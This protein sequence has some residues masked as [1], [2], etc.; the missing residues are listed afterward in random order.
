RTLERTL[1]EALRKGHVTLEAML[2]CI[3]RNG[4]RG[5]EGVAHL[6]SLL[7]ERRHQN[8]PDSELETDVAALLREHGIAAPVKRHRA[9]ED[10]HAIAEVDLAWPSEKVA[11]QVHGSSFHRRPRTW[12]N[13]QRVENRLQLHGWLVVKV[14][15]RM[16]EE[17]PEEFVA[18][19]ERA[20]S[21]RGARRVRRGVQNKPARARAAATRPCA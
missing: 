20:L 8:A 7:S 13:D 6:A 18:L 14:T 10:D 17:A 19:I 15:R 9:I 1:D 3:A 4:R 2:H 16:H 12:E 21:A 5:R 11:V